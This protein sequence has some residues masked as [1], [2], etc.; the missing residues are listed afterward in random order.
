MGVNHRFSRSDI[1][2][3][4]SRAVAPSVTHLGWMVS[5]DK[6]VG[7]WGLGLSYVIPGT[8]IIDVGYNGFAGADVNGHMSSLGLIFQF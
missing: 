7:D 6:T 8:M 3:F 4:A 5:W 1:P 2:G